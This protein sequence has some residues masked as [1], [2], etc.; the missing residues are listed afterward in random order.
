LI[1]RGYITEGE[2]NYHTTESGRAYIGQ[3]ESGK[4]EV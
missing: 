3:V 4:T 2:R 1:L